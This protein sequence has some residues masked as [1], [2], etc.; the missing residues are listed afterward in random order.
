MFKKLFGKFEFHV[1]FI[2]DMLIYAYIVQNVLKSKGE[3]HVCN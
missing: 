2:L 1:I 3:A